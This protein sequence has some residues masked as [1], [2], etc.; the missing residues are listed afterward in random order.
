MRNSSDTSGG[1]SGERTLAQASD[2]LE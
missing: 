1:R 2:G